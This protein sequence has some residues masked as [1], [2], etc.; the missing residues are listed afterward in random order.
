MIKSNIKLEKFKK[1]LVAL[2]AIYLRP[3]QDDRVIV[4]ATIQRFEFTFELSWKFLKD[5]FWEQ[6]LELTYPK[7]V[8]R[9]AFQSHLI[10]D[11]GLWISMLEDRNQ[12]SHTY[13][14][15]LAQDIYM[16]IKDYVPEL[17]ALLNQFD[18]PK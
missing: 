11:E 16:R 13:D 15:K 1:T 9:Q 17:R 8:L 6:G 10:E 5:Y 4:D 18:P 2:E 12:T 7:A 14:E 3:V